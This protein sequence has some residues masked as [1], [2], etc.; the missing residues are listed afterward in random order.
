MTAAEAWFRDRAPLADWDDAYANRAHVPDA[1]ALIERLGR[2]ASAYR[3]ALGARAVLDQ[4]YASPTGDAGREVFDIFLPEGEPRGLLVFFHGGYWVAFDKSSWSHLA[5]GP[6]ARGW[7]VAMASYTLA[8]HASLTQICGQA[9]A[10]VGAAAA[11]VGGPIVVS[12][13]SAGGHLAARMMC[14]DVALPADLR[15]RMAGAVTISGVHDLR[16]LLWTKLNETLRLD[17]AEAVAQ[18]PAL[19]AP[20]AGTRLT[21]WV[22]E[23]ERPEFLR[24]SELI[25]NIW[26]GLGAATRLAIEPA[27]HHFDV[28]AGMVD[29]GSALTAV[30]TRD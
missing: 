11:M 27:R 9:V 5:A 2:D 20:A 13:H 17:A 15:A 10:A 25:A 28:I 12:G 24:Q 7:A 21:A 26:A 29:A 30:L 19:L 16:P 6:V 18:S 4:R 3:A 8:P 14:A 22:G 23:A 1:D